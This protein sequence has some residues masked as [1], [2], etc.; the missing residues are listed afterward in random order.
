MKRIIEALAYGL[1]ITLALIVLLLVFSSRSYFIDSN[2]V[3]G[4]F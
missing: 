3:Y 2:V 4:R 1:V